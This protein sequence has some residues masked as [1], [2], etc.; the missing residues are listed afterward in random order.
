MSLIQ[1]VYALAPMYEGQSG[2]VSPSYSPSYGISSLISF[3]FIIGSLLFPVIVVGAVFIVLRTVITAAKTTEKSS[4]VKRGYF[5][6]MSFISLAFVYLSASDLIRVLLSYNSGSRPYYG[7]YESFAVDLVARASILIVVFP[8]FLFHWLSAIKRP[9][10][11]DEETLKY[12]AAEKHAYSYLVLFFLTILLMFMGSAFVYYLM[13]F[14][15]GISGV[16]LADFAWP[17]SYTFVGLAIWFYHLK[18]LKG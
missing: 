9:T 12:M 14:V 7:S 15:L 18:V 17:F 16:T 5:Y 1:S 10:M 11:V 6:L 13:L 8:L 2:M 3:L 4:T